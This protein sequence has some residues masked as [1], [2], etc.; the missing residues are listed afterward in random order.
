M[1]ERVKQIVLGAPVFR[2]GKKKLFK[3][4]KKLFKVKKKTI[5]SPV[6]YSDRSDKDVSC[7]FTFLICTSKKS[8]KTLVYNGLIINGT[9]V[10]NLRY[11]LTKY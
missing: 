11:A 8:S 2:S 3:V 9:M 1:I 5:Q 6:I 10:N 7:L 4:K